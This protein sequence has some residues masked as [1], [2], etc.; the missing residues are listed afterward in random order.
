MGRLTGKNAIIT[1]AARGMGAAE[2]R[3]FVAEGAN[4]LL[5]D[6]LDDEG[7]SLSD[8]LGENLYAFLRG[9]RTHHP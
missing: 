7:A 5:C 2:A 8:E 6:I 4:V 9:F 1:G 3:L